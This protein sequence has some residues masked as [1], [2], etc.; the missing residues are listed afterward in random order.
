MTEDMSADI[1]AE[2]IHALRL[3]A[4]GLRHYTGDRYRGV[5]P[6]PDSDVHALRLADQAIRKA[7]ALAHG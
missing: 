7:E 1:T 4:E 2:L 3:C 6:M 5:S